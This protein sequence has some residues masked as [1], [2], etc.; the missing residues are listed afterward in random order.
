[1]PAPASLK[2]T[3][4][5]FPISRCCAATAEALEAAVGAE[6]A[7]AKGELIRMASRVAVSVVTRGDDSQAVTAGGA[8]PLPRGV[9]LEAALRGLAAARA[10]AVGPAR[11]CLP[12]RLMPSNLNSVSAFPGTLISLEIEGLFTQGSRP[13]RTVGESVGGIL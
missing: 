3:E 4:Q 5:L 12:C 9:A 1:M 7:G 6:A 10:A 2:Q 8:A 11:C 13:G